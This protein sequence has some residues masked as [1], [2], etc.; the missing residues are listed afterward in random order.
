[1]QCNCW[2]LVRVIILYSTRWHESSKGRY[3]QF[4]KLSGIQYISVLRSTRICTV[5]G[6]RCPQHSRNFRSTGL[7]GARSAARVYWWWRH[8]RRVRSNGGARHYAPVVI[9]TRL[10]AHQAFQSDNYH[11]ITR[12]SSLNYNINIR[13]ERLRSIHDKFVQCTRFEFPEV[14]YDLRV[15]FTCRCHMV[16]INLRQN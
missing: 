3:G 2:S 16:N 6:P 11:C 13:Y 10:F 4:A 7:S 1:M 14:C 9:L 12:L 5:G 15:Q 8:F